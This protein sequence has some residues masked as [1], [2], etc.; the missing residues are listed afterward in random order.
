MIR[1]LRAL[2]PL[3]MVASA[4]FFLGYGWPALAQ[5]AGT[6]EQI[7]VYVSGQ[8]GYHTYRIPSV[9]VTNKGTV[10]AFCEGRKA[11][12]GD[13]G[14]ID[15]MLKRSTDGGKTFSK[16]QVV[17][18]DAANTCGNPCPVQDRQ[19]GKIVLF[20]THNLGQDR[21]PEI[22]AKTS[23]GTRTV[24]K[25]VSTDDGLTWSPPVEVTA[26]TKRADW[27]WYATGPG[28][29]IQMRSGRLVIPCDHIE[30]GSKQMKSHVLLSDDRGSSWRIGGIVGPGVN[31]CEV[32]ERADGSLLLNMRNYDRALRCRRTAVSQD[33]GLSWSEPRFDETLVEPICQASI[34]RYSWPEA[35]KSRILFSNPAATE[36]KNMTVRLSDDEG[37]TWAASRVLH[38]GPAA[39]SCLAVAADG[40]ILCLYERGE[41]SAYEK[42]SLARLD[43]DWLTEAKDR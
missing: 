18:D 42:I 20:L 17:W 34:R 7:D 10:L 24:W 19:S 13:A 41:K 30:A 37:Q 21:E 2:M 25:S 22:I 3:S 39:Y 31:E 29:G 9:L 1:P 36:R 8:D 26:S 6:L 16:A 27:T 43:L 4:A 35:G 23:Q 14:N 15:L 11:G 12:M 28:A 33:G 5:A 40:T 32:V 38:A